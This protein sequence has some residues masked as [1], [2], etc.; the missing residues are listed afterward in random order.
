MAD[1]TVAVLVGPKSSLLFDRSR[2]PWDTVSG[3]IQER[4][5]HVIRP[6]QILPPVPKRPGVCQDKGSSSTFSN[7][8][9][10]KIWPVSPNSQSHGYHHLSESFLVSTNLKDLTY[11]RCQLHNGT[12]PKRQA[13]SLAP[14]L[15]Q[16]PGRNFESP[17]FQQRRLRTTVCETR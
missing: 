4:T 16:P 15:L 12:P 14:R 9:N 11:F 3:G 6:L 8:V 10:L 5:Y 7:R 2:S 1:N 17:P 13:S